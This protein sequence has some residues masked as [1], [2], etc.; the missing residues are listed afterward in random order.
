MSSRPVVRALAR[1]IV[2]ALAAIVPFGGGL[3]AD[4]QLIGRSSVLYAHPVQAPILDPFRPPA[5]FGGPGNRGLQ[6]ANPPSTVVLAA[7]DGRILHAGQIV[8]SFYITMEHADGLETTYTGLTSLSVS[9]NEWVP[10]GTLIAIAGQNMHFGVKAR[11]R[12]LD[13]Q[14]L[15]DASAQKRIVRLIPGSA[16]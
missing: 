8:G 6:Y 4:G 5:H 15:I 16:R 1:V 12:Y 11:D 7:A 3:P 2:V 14:I 10:Q 13:P 9:N